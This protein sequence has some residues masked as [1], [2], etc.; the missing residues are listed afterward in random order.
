MD[1]FALVTHYSTGISMVMCLIM[2]IAGFLAFGEKTKGN[3][4]NNFPSG[5][6]MVNIARLSVYNSRL[7]KLTNLMLI[8][9]IPVASD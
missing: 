5:N 1:R 4:L 2:A 3:V 9:R 8:R 7:S 6:V